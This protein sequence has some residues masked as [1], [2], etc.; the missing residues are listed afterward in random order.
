MIDTGIKERERVDRKLPDGWK[1][2]KLGDCATFI[3]G[4]A[5]S[6]HEL[7]EQGIPVLRIQNLN[8]GSHWYYS[9]LELPADK[10]CQ[11]GDLLFAW[12]TTFGPYIWN[13]TKVIFHY[14][15]W[16]VL[17]K[18]LLDKEF[19][20]YLFS[21]I[22]DELKA[23][24][25]GTSMLHITK[26]GVES[27]LVPIPSIKEQK[28]IAAI[29]NEQIEA[30]EKAR[31]ATEAQLEA[32]KELPTA[33]L[34][35]VFNSPEA[36]KWERKKLGEI[37]EISTGTTPSTERKDYYQGNIPFI[38]TAQVVNNR[39]TKSEIYISQQ[40]LEDYSLKLYPQGTVIMAMYGQG[41]TRGQVAI[42]DISATTTQ[43]A[44]AIIPGKNLDSEYLWIW[45][46]GQYLKLRQMG[47]QGDLSHLS[48]K[49][50]KDLE[51]PVP[52]I[53]KQ[54]IIVKKI[55]DQ[56]E[57]IEILEKSL[58]SQLEAI[59]QLPSAILRKAFNG[60]L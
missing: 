56:M 19:A 4:R 12:S 1:W 57:G 9:D 28:R 20:Y 39:I 42:L 33:Y 37:S 41:K 3:N 55:F 36:Q 18:D 10:Y 13:G 47:Y 7:L 23:T 54:K 24:S 34:R 26:S 60:Q 25:H 22:T 44:A 45:L 38:K 29:L 30:V 14:H 31:N 50:V 21:K 32:A 52:D 17:T 53:S 48:L 11:A 2:V 43:N 16:K 8:G 40:A 59:N 46:R 49:Y 51:M 35:A 15:I 27:W 6:Q 5:Y 58:K